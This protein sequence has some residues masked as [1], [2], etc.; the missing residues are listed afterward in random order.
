M[1]ILNK[2]KEKTH[3]VSSAWPPS[4]QSV[5]KLSISLCLKHRWSCSNTE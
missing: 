3:Q 4:L 5:F 1:I 2:T